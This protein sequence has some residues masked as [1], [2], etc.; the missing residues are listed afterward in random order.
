MKTYLF[1]IRFLTLTWLLVM[2]QNSAS[3][4]TTFISPMTKTT[5]IELYTSEGCSSCPPADR[6]LSKLK[7]HDQL[8]KT[9]F[10]VAFHVDYWDYIG[11]KDKFADKRF[12]LRQYAYHQ[13]GSVSTVYTP[14]MM[15]DGREWRSWRWTDDPIKSNISLPEKL[16]AT[17]KTTIND[18]TIKVEFDRAT[19]TSPYV[20]NIALLGMNRKSEVTAGENNGKTLIHDFVVIDFQ[21]LPQ[22]NNRVQTWEIDKPE[23][24]NDAD[25]IV[26]WVSRKN[27]PTPLQ[28]TGGLLP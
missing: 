22:T 25:A 6:W 18:K 27:N 21:R 9:L 8:W 5:L 28:T 19:S 14:G 11:W 10:P 13:A 17:L 1:D 16:K 2:G 23:K 26:S 20:L 4:S 7:M 12:T 24:F 15:R 3:A